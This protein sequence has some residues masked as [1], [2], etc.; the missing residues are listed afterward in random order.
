MKVPV[1]VIETGAGVV[2]VYLDA[3]ARD[4]WARDIVL[5]AKTQRPSVCNA[6]ETVLVHRGVADRLLPELD[7]VLIMTVE[8]GFGGQEFLDLCLPKIE[9][10]RRLLSETGGDI[11]L[12][13]DG[14]VS[15]DTIERCAEAGM[16]A[17]LSKP[18]TE[19]EL[20]AVMAAVIGGWPS[21]PGWGG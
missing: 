18:F 3:T 2:H 16:D 15:V 5:N 11:W 19:E 1:P 6:V 21:L 8:P 9:R 17:F 20:R 14:G 4:D 12:Q 13:V 10:T 7:L